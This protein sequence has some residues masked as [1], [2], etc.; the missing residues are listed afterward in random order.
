MF[1]QMQRL[2]HGDTELDTYLAFLRQRR[3][4]AG[5]FAFYASDAEIFR[6]PARALSASEETPERRSANGLRI[7][8]AL[9]AVQW[10]PAKSV[11]LGRRLPPCWRC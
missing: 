3:P 6:F 8:A 2:A 7:E 9:A 11:A 5:R 10:G 1:Q 4:P